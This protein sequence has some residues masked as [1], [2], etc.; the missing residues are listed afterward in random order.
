MNNYA[1]RL[2]IPEGRVKEVLD[3]LTK[4]QQEIVD[5]YDELRRLGVLTIREE[6][7]EDADSCN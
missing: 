5:C 3:R 7:K 4:A 1:I 2:E 6:S